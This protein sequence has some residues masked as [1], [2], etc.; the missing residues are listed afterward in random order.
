M[1][2]FFY[3]EE[4]FLAEQKVKEL[5]NKFLAKNPTGSGL[6]VFEFDQE[7]TS[8][9]L[10]DNFSEQNLFTENKLII[11]KD[12]FA[13][14]KADDQNNLL[15]ILKKIELSDVLVFSEKIQ[16]RK[17]GRL[18]KWLKKNAKISKK[19]SK[20]QDKK[21]SDWIKKQLREIEEKVNIESK[22]LQELIFLTGGDLRKVDIELNKLASYVSVG[23]ITLDDIHKLV[24][25]KVEADIFQTIE[26]VF[27][28]DKKRAM[29]LL[30]QQLAK[31][32]DPFYIFSMYVYQIRVLL[33]ISGCMEQQNNANEYSIAKEVK[34]HPF[35]VKKSLALIRG[36]SAKKFLN[37]HHLLLSLDREVKLGKRKIE[38][39]LDFFVMKV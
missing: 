13:N 30:K 24:A 34:L 1:I 11:V 3:G 38:S 23:E 31:G 12:F 14:T 2:L 15:D 35:V 6:C 20:L 39:A 27:R 33:K 26:L 16:P 32:D 5:K 10:I 36:L 7:V 25:N 22:T 17:N 9:N 29:L 8:Q 21:L 4:D 18:F 37:A 19:F 28:N